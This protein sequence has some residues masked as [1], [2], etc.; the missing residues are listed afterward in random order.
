M[1]IYKVL[2]IQ[3]VVIGSPDFCL[4]HQQ[5]WQE[6]YDNGFQQITGLDISDVW[7]LGWFEKKLSDCGVGL[8]WV[9]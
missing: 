3:T 6:L 1:I 2:Y 8:G 9:S 4:N 5:I 7:K